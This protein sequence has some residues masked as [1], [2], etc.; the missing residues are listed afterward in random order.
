MAFFSGL[1]WIDWLH[2]ILMVVI[3]APLLVTAEVG[4]L[5]NFNHFFMCGVPGGI[6]YAMLF[7]VKHGWL[8]PITEKKYNAIINVWCRAPFL[9]CTSA[10]A[11][12]QFFVQEEFVPTYI[13]L[14]RG[15]LVGLA[16]WNGLFFMER[17]VGNVH[18]QQYKGAKTAKVPHNADYESDE[19]FQGSIVGLGMRV[20][21]SKQDLALLGAPNVHSGVPH[22]DAKGFDETRKVR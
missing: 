19:H 15:F 11:Y 2:H 5:M 21:V 22:H 1:S 7:A 16:C 17:V 9:V 3:G 12:I 14:V 6:D 18:V 10:F 8:A 20:A 13:R 4:P